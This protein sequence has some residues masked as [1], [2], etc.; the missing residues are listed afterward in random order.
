[1]N[2]YLP[3]VWNHLVIF[4]DIGG[5]EV[6]EDVN[7][8]HDVNNEVDDGEGV[9]V[10]VV[11]VARRIGMIRRILLVEKKGCNVRCEDGSVYDEDE[12]EP[13][14]DCLEGWVV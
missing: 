1:M 5:T 8:E 7:N 2:S 3:G 13:I 12:D 4:I 10:T 11:G 9:L 6:D 14:P